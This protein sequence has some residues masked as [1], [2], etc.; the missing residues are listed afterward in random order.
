MTLVATLGAENRSVTHRSWKMFLRNSA[1]NML[2]R[3]QCD[4][5]QASFADN[6]VG[7]IARHLRTSEAGSS[8][9]DLI[10]HGA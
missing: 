1:N 5:P 8:L 6:P 7:F 4:V 9:L 2:T 3:P 10:Y